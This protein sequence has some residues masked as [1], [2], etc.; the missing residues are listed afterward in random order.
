MSRSIAR[1]DRS[2]GFDQVFKTSSNI[3]M[4]YPRETIC[5]FQEGMKYEIKKYVRKT[6]YVML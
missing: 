2:N 1:T 3:A 4:S 5:S 6:D